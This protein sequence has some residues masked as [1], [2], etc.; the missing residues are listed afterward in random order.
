MGKD[1]EED[2]TPMAMVQCICTSHLLLHSGIQH[3]HKQLD[4]VLL[5]QLFVRGQGSVAWDG[6]QAVQ[7]GGCAQNHRT[8]GRKGTRLR[9]A[10]SHSVSRHLS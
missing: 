3:P 7:G 10:G 6:R 9:K 1:E 4:A 2:E 5:P 8:T